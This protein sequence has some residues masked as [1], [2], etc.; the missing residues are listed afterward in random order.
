MAKDR[1]RS[2]SPVN[3]CRPKRLPM[4]TMDLDLT[5]EGAKYSTKLNI[6]ETY[7]LT[8]FDKAILATQNIQQVEKVR[9]FASFTLSL[10][11]SFVTKQFGVV[12]SYFRNFLLIDSQICITG[13]PKKCLL[14]ASSVC[15]SSVSLIYS[16]VRDGGYFL[17]CNTFAGDSWQVGRSGGEDARNCE[18]RHTAG[19]NT[20]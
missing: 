18:T 15:F 4:W 3:L 20:P 5:P 10:F 14:L 12:V 16:S 17:C 19:H 1:W 11:V 2:S 6:F 9:L 8:I 13:D 7:L